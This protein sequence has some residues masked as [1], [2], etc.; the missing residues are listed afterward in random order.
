MQTYAVL[1]LAGVTLAVV[2]AVAVMLRRAR[3]SPEEK[4]RERRLQLNVKG[5]ITD[6]SLLRLLDREGRRLVFYQYSV[7]RVTYQ[8]SQDITTLLPLVR[9][10]GACE[11][12]PASVKYDPLNPS[13]SIVVCE[14]WSGLR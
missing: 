5:R 10:D 13:D 9:L 4:E 2:A 1:L 7:A 6:A 3:K 12:L 11:G 8:A 14:A